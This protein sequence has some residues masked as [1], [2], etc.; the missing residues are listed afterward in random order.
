MGLLILCGVAPG[1][2][3]T[4]IDLVEHALARHLDGLSPA[5]LIGLLSLKLE[6][7]PPPIRILQGLSQACSRGRRN[8]RSPGWG[9]HTGTLRSLPYRICDGVGFRAKVSTKK[10]LG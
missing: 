10:D 2:G 9:T 4:S 5:A 3:Q 1:S 7:G 6:Y 8:V